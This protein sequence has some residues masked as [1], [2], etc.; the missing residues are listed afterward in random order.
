MPRTHSV[1]TV[2]MVT[3]VTGIV[4]AIGVTGYLWFASR[5]EQVRVE[6]EQLRSDYISF[7]NELLRSQVQQ[8]VQAVGYER[9]LAEQRLRDTIRTRTLEAHA[10]ASTL[11]QRHAGTTQR[12]AIADEIRETLRPIRYNQGR[13]Y[14]FATAMDGVEQLFAD[15]PELEGVDLSATR[16]SQGR[17]V[18]RDM[19]EIAREPGEGF[20][21]Y[22]WTRPG[23][24][25]DHYRKIAFVKYFE[26]LDWFIGTGEYL[27]DVEGDIQR[28][29]LA[30]IGGIRFSDDGI[31]FAGTWEGDILAG[32]GQGQNMLS[33]RDANGLP[34]V[35]RMIEVAR[36]GGGLISYVM[37]SLD[38]HRSEPKVS[39]VDAIPE[40]R[41]YVGA[42]D[43]LSN[44]DRRVERRMT[45]FEQA[46][47]G[48]LR[49]ILGTLGLLLF[50]ALFVSLYLRRRIAGAVQRFTHFFDRAALETATIDE[51]RLGFTEFRALARGA[52]LMQEK[53]QALEQET[54]RLRELLQN[55]FD[56]MPSALIG[57]DRQARVTQ[58]NDQAFNQTGIK[59]ADALDQP[60]CQVFPA[61]RSQ[62]HRISEA[63]EQAQV[64]PPLRIS[65]NVDGVQRYKE[66]TIYPLSAEK[67]PGAVVRIDDVTD[68]INI[69]AMMVQSEKMLS[70]GG[71]AAGMAHEINNP[72]AGIVQNIQVIKMR[73][74][75]EVPRN[76]SV[77]TE[78]GV[79]LVAINTYLA[80]RKVLAMLDAA[81][82]SGLRAARIVDN[83]LSFSRKTDSA[84][85][86]Q[87]VTELLDRTVELAG[88][89]YDLKK[90]YDFRDIEVV[91][92]YA[93]HLPEVVCD[94]G[95]LQ[96][97][98]LNLL[99]NGA[100]AMAET[101]SQ[102]Q[103][104]FTLR[105][106]PV[107]NSVQISIEDNGPGMNETLAKRVFEP[108]FTTKEI[109]VGTGLGL[110][111]S[112]FIVTQT[113]Q[114]LMRCESA[115]GRGTHFIITLPVAGP[116]VD[117]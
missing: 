80:Q 98:F 2:F 15:R 103:G 47:I 99:R 88:N 92:D 90:R 115:P 18:I 70:V 93:P 12:E 72:L 64:V 95:Q 94:A 78:V 53:R 116:R 41:W 52:N 111:V 85:Q 77:A 16:D 4:L 106:A 27:D 35:E 58:W 71:L 30:R 22:T 20:Y 113:H 110:S 45:R 81:Q 32:P 96:Q 67:S 114:G 28:E 68:R 39:Y 63:I 48:H 42:S 33:I 69:E 60:V 43:L 13:G 7:Q 31:L 59:A 49:D 62:C 23:V 112:Y 51:Q 91:R 100:H 19:I 84:L 57:V 6:G 3:F 101:K 40:W 25:G 34:I 5:F 38:G 89:D 24:E 83:M 97:V 44:L 66:I 29:V 117:D 54:R 108:F 36:Q 79:D 56:S 17:Y 105:A 1:S 55:V 86:P 87:Q 8:V 107:G 74:D 65:E 76:Q 104:C 37:P 26:P 102:R 73:L 61:I 21:E 109:G 9:S 75:A 46:N 50:A 11:Y 14:F 10:L 82:E